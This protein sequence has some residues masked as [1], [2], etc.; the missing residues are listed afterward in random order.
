M[1]MMLSVICLN[2]MMGLWSRWALIMS[3]CLSQISR[4]ECCVMYKWKRQK[5]KLMY[6]TQRSKNTNYGDLL[7]EVGCFSRDNTFSKRFVQKNRNE[8]W[9]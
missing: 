2:Q 5:K 6:M 7:K 4:L 8:T 3:L 9:S 1:I